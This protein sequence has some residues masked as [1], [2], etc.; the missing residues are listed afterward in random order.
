MQNLDLIQLSSL[1][2]QKKI[3]E[4]PLGSNAGDSVSVWNKKIIGIDRVPWCG[5]Y[6]SYLTQIT[7]AT[8]KFKTG[9]AIG[10]LT[11]KSYTLKQVMRGNIIPKRGWA[12]VKS[13]VG[14]NHIDF[15]ID[16]DKTTHILT[17]IGGNVGDRVSIRKVKLCLTDKKSYQIFTPINI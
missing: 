1:H 2:L 12:V 11:D 10:F 3:S 9:R 13:R 4:Q 5:T 15:V 17:V 14:G 8:P 7:D 6:G 16:Y